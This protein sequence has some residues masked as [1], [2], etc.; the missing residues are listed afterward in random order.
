MGGTEGAFVEAQGPPPVRAPSRAWRYKDT[1]FLAL[2]SMLLIGGVL[3]A[4]AMATTRDP[5]Y[6]LWGAVLCSATGII[7]GALLLLLGWRARKEEKTLVAFS[8]RIKTYRRIPPDDLV[9]RLMHPRCA[10]RTTLK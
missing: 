2:G 1:V 4:T 5:F 9:E 6:V 7:P 10:H 8:A 3:G